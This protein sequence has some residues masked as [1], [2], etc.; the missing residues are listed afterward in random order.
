MRLGLLAALVVLAMLA[1]ACSVPSVESL[2]VRC[3]GQSGITHLCFTGKDLSGQASIGGISCG[4]NQA[5]GQMTVDGTV[6]G[7]P[8]RLW[9]T[10]AGR[11]PKE[12]AV[13]G[14]QPT[15]RLSVSAAGLT[16]FRELGI[17]HDLQLGSTRASFS[18][19]GIPAVAPTV[20]LTGEVDC[21]AVRL[22][23]VQRT[24]AA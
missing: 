3:P 20:F 7:K 4:L 6:G 24:T 13:F 11:T 5:A 1:A 21:P 16:N 22:L 2:L 18:A 19:T 10:P 14:K 15:V 8:F 23:P 12:E 9:I 17:S